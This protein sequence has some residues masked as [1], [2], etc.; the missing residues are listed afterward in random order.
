MYPR[1]AP[2]HGWTSGRGSPRRE[3][4]GLDGW[5]VKEVVCE[6]VRGSRKRIGKGGGLRKGKRSTGRGRGN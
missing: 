4:H 1:D 2:S 5:E 6:G 3:I